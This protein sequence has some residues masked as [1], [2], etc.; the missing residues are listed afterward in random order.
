MTSWNRA[1]LWAQSFPLRHVVDR[2]F[3]EHVRPFLLNLTKKEDPT[4]GWKR[5]WLSIHSTQVDMGALHQPVQN[6]P[7]SHRL[8]HNVF[9]SRG[10]N[11]HKILDGNKKEGQ[12]K[13]IDWH[14]GNMVVTFLTLPGCGRTMS[15]ISG[16]L[17]NSI[18]PS[19]NGRV[20]QLSQWR[21][22]GKYEWR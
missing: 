15:K 2:I 4:A 8:L 19:A 3:N 6:G 5:F 12:L 13:T 20:P 14:R 11:Y 9:Q 1:R 7:L 10:F 17:G 16:V 21:R 18:L 22:R